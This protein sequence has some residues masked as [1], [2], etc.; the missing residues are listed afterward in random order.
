VSDRARLTVVVDRYEWHPSGHPRG[1][2][3]EFQLFGH[4]KGRD[5]LDRPVEIW[6]S[7]KKW[8]IYWGF[9]Q[10]NAVAEF[11]FNV[12]DDETVPVRADIRHGGGCCYRKIAGRVG[13][14][15]TL[16]ITDLPDA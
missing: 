5:G 12:H 6:T 1:S 7:S 9:C 4:Y 16:S 8:N 10:V 15:V 11:S 14:V 13:R 3:G 2:G